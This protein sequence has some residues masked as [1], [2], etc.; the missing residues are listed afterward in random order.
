MEYSRW[1]NIKDPWYT[2]GKNVTIIVRISSIVSN[3]NIVHDPSAYGGVENFL[4]M[5]ILQSENVIKVKDISNSTILWL[6]YLSWEF[7]WEYSK[8][9]WRWGLKWGRQDLK[10]K[11][12]SRIRQMESALNTLRPYDTMAYNAYEG[13]SIGVF[14]LTK[15]LTHPPFQKF[16]D[17]PVASIDCM[18]KIRSNRH[19]HLVLYQRQPI[20]EKSIYRTFQMNPP[21]HCGA[22]LELSLLCLNLEFPD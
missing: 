7:S 9:L 15:I 13:T 22:D 21:L 8:L 3:V 11:I 20:F 6:R 14:I 4:S 1:E 17:P 16:L 2:V 18:N 5:Y 19:S 12:K 10:W